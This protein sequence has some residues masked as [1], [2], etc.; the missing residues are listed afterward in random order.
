MLVLMSLLW[1]CG[2]PPRQATQAPVMARDG[3]KQIQRGNLQ[4][5]KGCYQRAAA[6]FS[7]VH[8][9]FTAADDLAGIAVSLNS[10]GNVYQATGDVD[11]AVAFFDEALTISTVRG[12]RQ[13]TLQAMANKAAALIGADR[14]DDAQ[15]V[16]TAAAE[17]E[18]GAFLP[19]QINQGILFLKQA[20]YPQ[21]QA[22]LETALAGVTKED[23]SSQAKIQ[24]ALGRLKLA[25]GDAAAAG[26]HLE[27]ALAAD[28]AVG[29]HAGMAQDHVQLGDSHQ[30]QGSSAKA[31]AHYKQAVK[32]YALLGDAPRVKANLTK[33]EKA[34]D[35]AGADIRLTVHFAKTW[36][37]DKGLKRPC[38]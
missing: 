24:F 7:R 23:Q 25:Q 33:L 30:A 11:N 17:L 10:L 28:R 32:I 35:A 19:L 9:E 26:E 20:A 16:L 34:A 3:A 18:P 31:V 22:A 12:D 5:T 14:L 27:Q 29:F 2:S 13:A 6:H 4:Y 15:A 38:R 37:E 36:L 8:A 1:A 21:A